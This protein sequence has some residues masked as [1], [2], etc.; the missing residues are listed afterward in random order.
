MKKILLSFSFIFALCI[1]SFA[2]TVT[3]TGSVLDANG[4]GM[5][6]YPVYIASD[7][8]AMGQPYFNTVYTNTSGVFTDNNATVFGSQGVYHASVVDS[9]TGAVLTQSG[10]YNPSSLL[11]ANLNFSICGIAPTCTST[12]TSSG[13]DSIF[14]F[15]ATSNGTAPF[16]YVWDLGDGT[17]LTN[18]GSSYTHLY[19]TNGTFNACVTIMDAAGC[20]SVTCNTVTVT[21][22]SGGGNGCSASYAYNY[23]IIA[24]AIFFSG[25]ATGQAPFTYNWDMG[26]GTT[27]T[28][29]NFTHS[30]AQTGLYAPCLTITDA[31]GCVSTYCDSVYAQGS[32]NNCT[33]MATASV[34]NMT[35]SFT[36]TATGQAP[37]T[38]S[39][40]FGDSS[41]STVANPT[42][43]YAGQGTYVACVT[44]TDA[45]GCV[46]TD[47]VMLTLMAPATTGD[48]FGFVVADSMT[49]G[50]SMSE[51]YLIEYDS[52][53]GTL[54]AIDTQSTIQGSFNFTNV[55]FGSYFVKGALLSSDPQYAN[56]LPTYY[57]QSLY[58]NN[59]TSVSVTSTMPQANAFIQL[60]QGSNP[61]GGAG[62]IG[63]LVTQGANGPGD[64]MEGIQVILFDANMNPIGYTYTD[65]NG[66]YSFDDLALGVYYIYVESLGLQTAPIQVTLSNSTTS[67]SEVN[68]EVGSSYVMFT[69]TENIQSISGVSVFP[70]PVLNALNLQVQADKTL[71]A[72]ISVVTLTGQVLINEART[73]TNGFNNVSIVSSNLPTGIYMVRVQTNEGV[74]TQKF[75]KQ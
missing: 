58:W 29:Q 32:V 31:T 39:W 33:A 16:T 43:T 24:P 75:V 18:A 9:C 48:I 71:D 11:V 34:N 72:N 62:F 22:Y 4:N 6:N 27:N 8:T 61:S 38:Y 64:P 36:A 15:T 59:A 50:T 46:S 10:T 14:T 23:G 54:T 66:N 42:H 45:T 17:T 25:Q 51:V 1:A 2:Q 47:C 41:V 7:S 65:E 49:F 5:S 74:I 60:I 28:T 13:Q 67:M 73:F 53:T 37:F 40:D 44:I 63:G 26:D 69:N 12:L 19:A 56:Y 52:T 30:Y 57:I 3:V 20:I 70:N 55:P 21:S 35:A 68:F